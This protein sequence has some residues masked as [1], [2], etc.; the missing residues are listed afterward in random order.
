MFQAYGSASWLPQTYDMEAQLSLLIG[1]YFER[2]ARHENNLWIVKPWNMARTLDTTVT[3][4]LPALIRLV[5]TG[6]KIAQ[7]YVD[8]PALFQGRKF[9]LRYI[10]LL[11]SLLP[12]EVY[13]CDVFWVGLLY[14]N[15]YSR[16]RHEANVIFLLIFQ[17][18]CS[19][20]FNFGR[21]GNSFECPVV[22][23]SSVFRASCFSLCRK[24]VL[25]EMS[26]LL[27][28][29]LSNNQYTTEESSLSE[30]ETHFTVMV[31]ETSHDICEFV[32]RVVDYCWQQLLV[33]LR[34][35]P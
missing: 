2:E 22:R 3:S 6:P 14:P 34:R 7:K 31:C 17:T 10:V 27:K 4:S 32:G 13:L 35:P 25:S 16:D 5:E 24:N 15:Q 30:Y 12:L 33:L 29:R 21:R 8:P 23:C 18:F 20:T 26:L 9:D 1:D 11:R 28:T 19:L